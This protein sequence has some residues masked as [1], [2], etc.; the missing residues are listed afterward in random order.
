[1]EDEQEVESITIE[2]G[3]PVD[4]APAPSPSAPKRPIEA[5]ARDKGMLPQILDGSTYALPAGAHVDRLG[6][7]P[8]AIGALA[9]P[10]GNPD[11]W[12][13]AAAKAGSQWP[14]NLEITEAEFDAAVELATNG[15][16]L[17]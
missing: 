15:H 9:G 17:R 10:R 7:A 14:E 13:F 6:G 2:Q 16:Q 5:W 3:H 12:R 11:F 4:A 8:V 1:M